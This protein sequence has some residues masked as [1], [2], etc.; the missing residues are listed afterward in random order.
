MIRGPL[1]A[2]TFDLDGTLWSVDDVLAA[3]EADLHAYLRGAYPAVAA[4]FAPEDVRALRRELAERQPGL[5]RN[6][7]TLRR[8]TMREMAHRSGLAGQ[9]VERFVARSFEVFLE[10]RQARVTPYPEVLPALARLAGRFQIG[11]I[12]NGNADVH[13]TELGPYVGFVVRGVDLDVPKPEPAIFSHACRCAGAAPAEVLHV[14]DDPHVDAAGALGAGLQ[15]ALLH[16]GGPLEPAD[17]GPDCPTVPDMA[18]LCRLIE[19]SLGAGA[20]DRG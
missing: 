1:R 6:A 2:L 15:A 16:R 8:A 3:A 18:A 12:T 10:A 14:G 11:V 20:P 4:R 9:E 5:T 17:G 19:Q 13:R 7:S